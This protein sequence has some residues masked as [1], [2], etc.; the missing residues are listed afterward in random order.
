[1]SGNEFAHYDWGRSSFLIVVE[2]KRKGLPPSFDPSAETGVHEYFSGRWNSSS[3]IAKVDCIEN[4]IP[5]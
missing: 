3:E 5:V 1:V 2:R 4:K